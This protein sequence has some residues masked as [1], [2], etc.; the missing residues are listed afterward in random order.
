MLGL[1][2]LATR[3]V[4]HESAAVTY[5]P[6]LPAAEACLIGCCVATGVGSVLETAHLAPESRVAVIGC[7]AVGLSVVQGARLAGAKEIYAVDRDK[8]RAGAAAHFGA[9]AS[10]W[11]EGLDAVFDAVGT[12]ET[13]HHIAALRSAGAYVLI[14]LPRPRA[15]GC[16]R[17]WGTF[18][19]TTSASS[20]PTA[21]TTCQEKIFRGLPKRRLQASSTSPVS[22]PSR[23]P[24]TISMP[25]CRTWAPGASCAQS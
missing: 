8:G 7:G 9:T 16:R 1:G 18:R 22:S 5:P 13:R 24:S 17:A 25:P 10:G 6:E 2:T 21:A 3:A 11:E 12:P 4:V 15:R 19:P 14:G 23:Y 20:S